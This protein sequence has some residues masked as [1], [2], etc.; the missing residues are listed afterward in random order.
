M[1]NQRAVAI[2]GA[3]LIRHCPGR[4]FR[5]LRPLRQTG[6]IMNLPNPLIVHRETVRPE[7]I[8]YNDHMNVAYYV[9]AFDHAIDGFFDCIGLDEAYRRRHGATTFAAECH[10][11][12]QRELRAGDPLRITARLIDHDAKRLRY[13]L[14][15]YHDTEDYLAATSE[16]LSL[17]VDQAGRRAVPMADA[18][19]ERLA[20]LRVAQR[21]L[22]L[23]PEV[24]RAVGDPPA[25][26]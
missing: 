2:A 24:G 14:E 15:M 11:T 4:R 19:A 25:R 17:H 16:W 7:W 5:Y 21:D 9:L 20:A 18:L 13:L 12:Y 26:R 23:A 10:V 22:P 6:K 8:D 3:R 1:G